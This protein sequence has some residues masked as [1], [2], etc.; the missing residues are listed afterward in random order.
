MAFRSPSSGSTSG[1]EHDDDR[2]DVELLSRNE[3][4]QADRVV[5]FGKRGEGGAVRKREREIQDKV[6][7]L[8]AIAIETA[9]SVHNR[10]EIANTP[11]GWTIRTAF[12]R[13]SPQFLPLDLAK[14]LRLPLEPGDIIRCQTNPCHDW[15]IS[16]FVESIDGSDHYFLLREI[17]SGRL[18]RMENE[19]FDVLRF[20]PPNMVLTGD[21]HKMYR[22]A[23]KAF[24]SRYNKHADYFKRC[25]GIKVGNEVLTIWSRPHVWCS[26]A[27]KDGMIRQPRKFT[28]PWNKK[29]RL[30]DIVAALVEQGFAEEFEF[31]PDEPSEGMAGCAKVTRSD[32][33]SALG[34]L[35]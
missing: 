10:M 26:I 6:R 1:P 15:G 24:S 34:N 29:T 23:N 8:Q 19:S 27:N 11:G 13:P 22:W 16:E 32:L 12:G 18:M 9:G 17:G 3:N 30:K 28:I 33:V 14:L 5:G 4:G 31:G 25:G 20:M 2:N 7:V 35:P 21:K